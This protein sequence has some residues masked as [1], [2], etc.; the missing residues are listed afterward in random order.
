MTALDW[1]VLVAVLVSFVVY[2]TW[3]GRGARDLDRYLLAGR[4]LK[5]GAIA[6]SVMA[7]QASA[8]T[9]LSTPGQGFADGLRFVQFYFGLPLAMV[10]LCIIAVPAYRRLRVFTAYEYLE[11]RFDGRTRSLAAGL[12]LVQRG[13]AA[14]LT[15]YAPALIL[16]VLLGWEIRW[17]CALLGAL[18]V[19]YTAWGGSQSVSHAHVLQFLIILATLLIAFAIVLARLPAGV[20]WLD[21]AALAGRLGRMNAVRLSFDLNDRYNL[22][23]GLIGGFFLQLSYFGTDQSQVGRYLTGR[24][25]RESRLGLLFNGLFKVPMQ[26]AILFLGVLLFA[27]DLFAPTP[28]FFNPLETERVSHGAHQVEWRALE[29]RHEGIDG[30]LA[31]AANA[32]VAARHAHDPAAER[33]AGLALVGAEEASKQVRAEASKLILATDPGAQTSDTNYIFLSFVRRLFPAG[34]VGLM[35]AAIFAASMNSTSAELNALT[36][37]TV[38]DVYRRLRGGIGSIGPG[39]AAAGT[40]RRDVWVSRLI[41]VGWTLFAVGF[42]EYASRLGS[43]IEA[44]N[45][46]GSLFYGT[47]LGIFLSAFLLPN[48]TGPSVCVAALIAEAAVI[49]CFRFTGI[50]FLWYNVLGCAVVMLIA[51]TLSAFGVGRSAVSSPGGRGA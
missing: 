24:D 10:V 36:S 30:R 38:V 3:R 44:V 31:V 51:L 1:T 33:R 50:S 22:A 4:S 27:F 46:L 39:D 28:L 8:I 29:R 16:S 34:L 6:I 7:T 41:T 23:S 13:L 26:T 40:T 45:I 14:G 5:S 37:T 2:G 19:V 12:F 48:V 25:V 43:L 21:A 42:A 47:I 17:T 35:L 20:G 11:Q 49:A 15:I 9:F 18:A 32:L